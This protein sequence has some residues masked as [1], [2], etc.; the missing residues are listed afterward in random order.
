[1]PPSCGTK[2]LTERWDHCRLFLHLLI[3][4]FMCYMNPKQ[5]KSQVSSEFM[6]MTV[7]VGVMPIS[8]QSLQNLKRSFHLGPRKYK[9]SPLP[10]IDMHQNSNFS[11]NLSQEKYISKIEPIHIDASRKY[12]HDLSV[13]PEEQQ[14]LRAL[15]G[16]LQY[17]AV[18]TRPDLSSRLSFLQSAVNSATIQ[19]LNEANKILHD[20]KRHK[21]TTI[22][23][24][25]IPN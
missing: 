17:A 5:Q 3:P 15:I 1:M 4:L 18:N 12:Q 8:K 22:T 10:V 7:F 2:N 23:V 25:P 6:S 9:H 19:T 20:A 14:A 16:S 13:T 11:I 24:Q 21:D